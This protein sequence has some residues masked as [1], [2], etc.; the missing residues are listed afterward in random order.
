MGAASTLERG[1]LQDANSADIFKA[2]NN[3]SHVVQN[4]WERHH[5]NQC[6]WSQE[7]TYWFRHWFR[8]HFRTKDRSQR[9]C[10][11]SESF[12]RKVESTHSLDCAWRRLEEKE[13]GVTHRWCVF[14]KYCSFSANQLPLKEGSFISFPRLL[15]FSVLQLSPS[16]DAATP[17]SQEPRCQLPSPQ[18]SG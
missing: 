7:T 16:Q 14:M 2:G 12:Q 13:Q 10:W 4:Y 18:I 17:T 6:P 9:A 8:Y 1:G 11:G 3:I 5:T 15:P